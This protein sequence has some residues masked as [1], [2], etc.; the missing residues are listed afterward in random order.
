[1]F[2]ALVA[3]LVHLAAHATLARHS[4]AAVTCHDG[5]CHDA[6]ADDDSS[7]GDHGRGSFAH[8]HLAALFPGPAFVI[9][10]FIAMGDRA[11]PT[12]L[13]APLEAL[14]APRSTARGPPPTARRATTPMQRPRR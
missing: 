14:D 10:P 1:M 7:D 2:G 12:D 9:P 5:H 8:G 6:S 4:H 3:P 13:L 11:R